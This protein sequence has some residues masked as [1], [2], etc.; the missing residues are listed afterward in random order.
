MGKRK[1]DSKA[2][3]RR[4]AAVKKDWN[5]GTIIESFTI[6]KDEGVFGYRGPAAGQVPKT[7]YYGGKEQIYF[8]VVPKEWIKK[9]P[10][11]WP[12]KQK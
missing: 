2:T 1:P 9:E 3:W 12:K 7:Y 10:M 8:P 11:T 4:E 6:P 5:D